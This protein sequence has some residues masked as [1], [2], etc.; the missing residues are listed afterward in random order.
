MKTQYG[1]ISIFWPILFGLILAA[2]LLLIIVKLKRLYDNFRAP[3]ITVYARLLDKHE[4]SAPIHQ[5]GTKYDG[6]LL[7][8]I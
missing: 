2:F 5:G 8:Y 3:K 1:D 4:N 7:F 6:F